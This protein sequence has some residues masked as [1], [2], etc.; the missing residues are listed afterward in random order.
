MHNQSLLIA[1]LFSLVIF[2]PSCGSDENEE[3]EEEEGA[4]FAPGE[5]CG[6]SNCS[7]FGFCNVLME[8]EQKLSSREICG[9]DG[10][11][12]SGECLNALCTEGKPE[13]AN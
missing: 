5:V 3:E 8:C 12:M 9:R 7:Q 2:I 1:F 11:C 10:E 13:C 4:C 6:D